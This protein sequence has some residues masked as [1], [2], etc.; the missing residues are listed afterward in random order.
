MN[1]CIIPARSGS[2]RIPNKNVLNFCGKPIIAWSIEAALA[3]HC[4]GDVIVSTDCTEIASIAASYGA[5]IPF[6]RPKSISGDHSTTEEVIHHAIEWFSLRRQC[7]DHVCCLYPTAPLVRIS[8][9][10]L[11]NQLLLDKKNTMVF[12]VVEFSFPPQ[13][14]IRIDSYGHSSAIYPQY[15]HSRSQDLEA[16]YHDA[17]QFYYGTS[18][19]WSHSESLYNDSTPIRIPSLHVQD[20][21]TLDD[22]RKAEFLFHYLHS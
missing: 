13:R 20:I 19:R 4:F 16:Y 15:E 11:A 8:D 14:A 9:L 10:K 22:W 3:S 21:D 1:L 2:K 18:H 17:G 12:P 6:I 5:S 7:F